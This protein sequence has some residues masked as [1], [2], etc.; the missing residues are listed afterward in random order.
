MTAVADT[1][2][3]CPF[4]VLPADVPPEAVSAVKLTLLRNSRP[5]ADDVDADEL[6]RLVVAVVIAVLHKPGGQDVPAA[7][8]LSLS[9]KT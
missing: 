6:A 4:P 7:G 8:G 9:G 2:L 3:S 1:A 5:P